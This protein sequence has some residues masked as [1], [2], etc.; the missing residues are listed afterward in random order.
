MGALL[1]M[2]GYTERA[3][4]NQRR[5]PGGSV[6]I[7][8]TRMRCTAVRRVGVTAMALTAIPR[9]GM[10]L[11]VTGCAASHAVGGEHCGR[12][13][14]IGTGEA[15]V[16]LVT[17]PD[18]AGNRLP[19]TDADPHLGRHSGSERF[20][21]MTAGTIGR[22]DFSCEHVL[23]MTEIATPGRLKH[24]S[25]SGTIDDVAGEAGQ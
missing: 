3:R 1:R 21:A 23:M 24:Q 25:G 15:R 12:T 6:T 11:L 9:G 17:K 10:V 13:V 20:R 2:A 18:C 7:G 5:D 16:P 19:R 22:Q 14:A 8:T 4:R